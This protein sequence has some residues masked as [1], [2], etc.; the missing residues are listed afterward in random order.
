[1]LPSR[2]AGIRPSK[3]H[4]VFAIFFRK[5]A[6]RIDVERIVKRLHLLPESLHFCGE[7]VRFH[8]VLRS[9]HGA[10]VFETHLLRA[11]VAEFDEARVPFASDATGKVVLL[12]HEDV[13]AISKLIKRNTTVHTWLLRRVRF[14][15]PSLRLIAEF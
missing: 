8:I 14:M 15:L 12:A 5:F 3:P 6:A 9:P 7:S 4:D 11:F 10:G 1:M 13:S 2:W